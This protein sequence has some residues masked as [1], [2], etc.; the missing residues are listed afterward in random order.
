MEFHYGSRQT[1]L[2]SVFP[3]LFAFYLAGHRPAEDVTD[4]FL[5]AMSSLAI[6]PSLLGYMSARNVQR[7]FLRQPDWPREFMKKFDS[8]FDRGNQFPAQL[9]RFL[10]RKR[11]MRA[12]GV[13]KLERASLWF[14]QHAILLLGLGMLLALAMTVARI[15]LTSV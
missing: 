12:R 6:V 15:L 5:A 10:A 2:L 1:I 3:I 14:G 8:S 9:F 7:I 13:V 4:S 11:A